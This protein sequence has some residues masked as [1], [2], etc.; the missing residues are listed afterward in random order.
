MEQIDAFVNRIPGWLDETGAMAEPDL[1]V[2]RELLECRA[3]FLGLTDTW[4][5]PAGSLVDTVMEVAPFVL[6]FD[7]AWRAAAVV[8]LPVLRDLVVFEGDPESAAV[9]RREVKT[10]HPV[11]TGKL[12]T[13]ME[14][15]FSWSTTARLHHLAAGTGD[16]DGWLAWYHELSWEESDR[17][18][19]PL[20]RQELTLGGDPY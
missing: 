12:G 6:R 2:L 20:R 5:W 13:K 3:S 11:L 18:A 15:A 19:G 8:T 14:D 7:A 9:L 16:G 4:N 17:L 1:D 10:L